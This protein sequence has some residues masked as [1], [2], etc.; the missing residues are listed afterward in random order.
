MCA[1]LGPMAEIGARYRLLRRT[2][3]AGAILRLVIWNIV[4]FPAWFPMGYYGHHYLLA[5]ILGAIVVGGS[6]RAFW[7][8][9]RTLEEVVIDD[10]ALQLTDHAGQTRRVPLA[11]LTIRP[12]VIGMVLAGGGAILRRKRARGL[13]YLSRRTDRYLQLIAH[14]APRVE[15]GHAFS[16]PYLIDRLRKPDTTSGDED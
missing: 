10:E 5:L 8:H 7:L 14:L 15:G 11:Q 3:P 12:S 9:L 2:S 13:W 4:G 1:T 16:S 6:L